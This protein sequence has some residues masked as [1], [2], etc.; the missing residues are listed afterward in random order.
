[1]SRKILIFS[2]AY[3]PKYVSG[4]EIA[5]KEITARIPDVEFHLIT[6]RFDGEEAAEER[7]GAVTVH[8]VGMGSSYFSKM[9]FL[10]RAAWRARSLHKRTHFDALWAMMSYMLLPIALARTLGVRVPYA[11]SLQEGDTFRHM[12]GRLR[13]L[14]FVPLLRR[15]LRA[16]SVVQAISH[17]LAEWALRWDYRGELVIIPN[18]VDIKHFSRPFSEH[19]LARAKA[20]FGKKA[21]DI[22][23]ITTSRLVEKNALD[24]VIR[25]LTFL[26][27]H[28]HFIVLGRGKEESALRKLAAEL[29][30]ATRV[31]FLG[32][33]KHDKLPECLQISDIF[34]RPSRSEGMGSSF[35]EAMAV[36]LPIVATQEGGI[37]DFLFDPVRNS[38]PPRPFGRASAGVISNGVDEKLVVTNEERSTHTS[39][40][41]TGWAV[42]KDSPEQIARAVKD[43]I[44][45]PEKMKEVVATAKKLA[46]EKY[47]WD[48]I[49][50][51]MRQKVFEPLFRR[52]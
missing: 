50:R 9:L 45:R 49:A 43:I 39:E 44:A 31:R 27:E 4:A 30:V 22:F 52:A 47:D 8:R 36:G 26:P 28:V 5:I 33:V 35:V 29:R 38:S 14:P 25:G 46:F 3:F 10:P 11:L 18:G 32:H 7:I 21:G 2:L 13:I 12:F 15:T 48:I 16:A 19:E 41:Q 17:H 20:E 42:D 40:Y 34:V 23:L 6:Q 37:A 24:D 1:M 51:D